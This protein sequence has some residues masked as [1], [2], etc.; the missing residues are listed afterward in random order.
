[1]FNVAVMCRRLLERYWCNNKADSR[2]FC[3]PN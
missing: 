1:M 3:Q 2:K